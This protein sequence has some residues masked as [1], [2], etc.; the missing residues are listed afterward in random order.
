[1]TLQVRTVTAP[2]R[3]EL[4][5]LVQQAVAKGWQRVGAPAQVT[6][7]GTMKRTSWQQGVWRK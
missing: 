6:F 2:D 7:N 3:R 4:E 1:M 5:R